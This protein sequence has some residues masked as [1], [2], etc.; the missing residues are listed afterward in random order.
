MKKVACTAVG[1]PE[2]CAHVFE[3]EDFE[4]FMTQATEHIGGKHPEM[5]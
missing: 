3:A 5:H 2:G 4:G 1:G